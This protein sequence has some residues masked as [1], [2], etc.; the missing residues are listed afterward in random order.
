[1][2]IAR[3]LVDGP[4]ENTEVVLR[5]LRET[6]DAGTAVFIVTHEE[7]TTAHADRTLRLD[8]GRLVPVVAPHAHEEG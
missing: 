1:M 2:A 3:A 6:A 7:Q 4:H 8:A 5:V